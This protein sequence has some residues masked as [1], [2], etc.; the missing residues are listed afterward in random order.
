MFGR[1]LSMKAILLNSG[2]GNRM[3]ELT[4]SSPKALV[5]LTTNITI[6]DYQ[7]DSLLENNIKD[8][9]ITTGPFK[10]QLAKH[11]ES[12]YP[13]IRVNFVHNPDFRTTNYIYS[14]HL[15]PN[16]LLTDDII[17]MHGDL[18]F[19]PEVINSILSSPFDNSV[20]VNKTIPRPKKDFKG[21]IINDHITEIRVDI[22]DENCYTLMPLYK[23][24]LDFFSR[25]KLEIAK[26]I[27]QGIDQVYAENA[28][29]DISDEILLQP[30]YY[31]DEICLEIDTPED[32]LIVQ[33]LLFGGK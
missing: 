19:S 23:L 15:I 17:L 30:V 5:H 6:L 12:N 28:F 7:L 2:V 8:I 9:I 10:D 16:E 11:I 14:M 25:W 26:Y 18:I 4:S 29:N 20:L 24:S 27:S 31:T 33:S 21:R 3:G 1:R 22:F 13:L 32:L